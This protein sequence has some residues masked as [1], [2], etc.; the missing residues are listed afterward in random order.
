M[1]LNH[2]DKAIPQD[3]HISACG[4]QRA[5]FLVVSQFLNLLFRQSGNFSNDLNVEHPSRFIPLAISIAFCFAPFMT[6]L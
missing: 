4:S 6:P 2:V 5:Y 3:K 1:P